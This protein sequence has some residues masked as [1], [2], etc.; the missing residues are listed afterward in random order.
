MS[1][2]GALARTSTALVNTVWYAETI[3]STIPS[4]CREQLLLD[5]MVVKG[6]FPDRSC[7]RQLCIFHARHQPSLSF[8]GTNNVG[9]EPSQNGSTLYDFGSHDL[10]VFA[11]AKPSIQL[12]NHVLKSLFPLNLMFPENDLQILE[13]SPVLDQHSLG[14]LRDHFQASA[15]QPTLCLPQTH[16]FSAPGFWRR[17]WTIFTSFGTT[18]E[19]LI[20]P[21]III[22]GIKLITDTI[23]HGYALHRLFG[24]SLHLLGAFWDSFTN[25]LL[26]LGNIRHPIPIYLYFSSD[27]ISSFYVK[28]QIPY[29][30]ISSNNQ[31]YFT[32]NENFLNTCYQNE[33]QT[34]CHSTRSILNSNNNSIC[35]TS[36]F[37]ISQ[38]HKCKIIITYSE[39][40]FLT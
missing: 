31:S 32:T 18:S 39:Y 24:W 21:I 29:L 11:E 10:H 28:S 25:L 38:P 27:V 6:T 20:G 14:L 15:I 3:I 30:A 8:P 7:V 36:M 19:G 4:L 37:L 26:H 35:E 5:S 12:R 34:F 23:I 22:R 1:F 16:W 33:L 2:G 9:H 17:F 13:G 40:P